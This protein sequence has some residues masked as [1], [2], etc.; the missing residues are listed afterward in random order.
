MGMGTE[1]GSMIRRRRRFLSPL[2]VRAGRRL[3][4]QTEL[5]LQLMMSGSMVLLQVPSPTHREMD[6]RV[7]PRRAEMKI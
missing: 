7:Q 3:L 4:P 2:E 1:M 6:D 5:L